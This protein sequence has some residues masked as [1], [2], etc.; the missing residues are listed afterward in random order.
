MKVDIT[1]GDR[2]TPRAVEY[3]FGLL[4]ENRSISILTALREQDIYWDLF[5]EAFKNTAEKRN[6]Y[7]SDLTWIQAVASVKKLYVR[8]FGKD[9]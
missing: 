5:I 8:A 2:I 7:V 9:I 4:F 6:S 1:T 3:S